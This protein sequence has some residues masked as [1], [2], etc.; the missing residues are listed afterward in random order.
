MG[1]NNPSEEQLELVTNRIIEIAE[2]CTEPGLPME[3]DSYFEEHGFDLESASQQLVMRLKAY[4]KDADGVE[5]TLEE[6]PQVR[7]M[8]R[9]LLEN[10]DYEILEKPLS[11]ELLKPVGKSSTP[12]SGRGVVFYA[13][14]LAVVVV[15]LM[16]IFMVSGSSKPQPAIKAAE[17]AIGHVR[18]GRGGK[19][20][21]WRNGSADA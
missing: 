7:R 14:V 13:A 15:L 21:G 3:A 17:A 4:C 6:Y 12:S 8:A 18:S 19:G 11:N 10:V 20:R 9:Y 2:T 16:L 5:P 1:T